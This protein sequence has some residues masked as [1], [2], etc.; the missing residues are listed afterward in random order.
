MSVK[1]ISSTD[2][3]ESSKNLQA[4]EQGGSPED[5]W[6]GIWEDLSDQQQKGTSSS[7]KINNEQQVFSFHILLLKL[8]YALSLKNE[9]EKSL[10]WRDKF[11]VIQDTLVVIQTKTDFL[12][13]LVERIHK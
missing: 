1:S 12:L 6:E 10:S 7:T 2:S 5:D 11:S 9:K 3:S 8:N 13:A 4:H